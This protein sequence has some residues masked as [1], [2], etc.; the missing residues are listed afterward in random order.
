MKMMRN[1]LALRKLSS[2]SPDQELTTYR[3]RAPKRIMMLTWN[4]CEMPRAKQRKIHIT[5]VL[6]SI[7][8]SA[9][10]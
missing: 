5:P 8:V 3:Q 7:V 9:F 4:R 1:E 6:P 10:V 2:L